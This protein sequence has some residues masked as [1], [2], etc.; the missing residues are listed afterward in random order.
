MIPGVTYLLTLTAPGTAPH[1]Y[2]P[3]GRWCPCTP[4]YGLDLAEWNGHAARNW[5]KLV[6]DLRRGEIGP[7]SY[8]RA[9][10][11]QKRGA[12][13][14]H[15]LVRVSRPVTLS[16]R[17]LRRLAVHHGF[18]HSVDLAPLGGSRA[19]AGAAGYVS[20]YVSK[21]V[22]DRRR[23]PYAHPVTGARGAGRWRTWTASR[24]W[25]V[26]MRSVRAEQRA[27]AAAQAEREATER[28][29][30]ARR[31]PG[32]ALDPCSDGYAWEAPSGPVEAPG[33]PM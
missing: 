28:S 1:R 29:E 22:D 7:L 27:W 23:V 32:A 26:T 17:S 10:E 14:F 31:P 8:F 11:I 2:G 9:V 3:H 30:G 5:N 12:I 18:G 6:T 20:K 21:S 19:R 4:D 15:V 24:C 16:M 33:L 25:G 13:H